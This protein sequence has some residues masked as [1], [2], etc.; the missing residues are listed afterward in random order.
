MSTIYL[1]CDRPDYE[2]G[3]VIRAYV[4]K[5]KA[6][7]VKEKMRRAHDKWKK[8]QETLYFAGDESA[9]VVNPSHRYADLQVVPCRLITS[10]PSSGR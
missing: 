6:E 10:T 3:T 2:S 5:Q 4:S 9:Y 8:A 1:L 7:G